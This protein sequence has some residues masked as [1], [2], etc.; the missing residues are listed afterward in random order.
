MPTP[1]SDT[2]RT[3][4]VPDRFQ[5]HADHAAPRSEL[6]R[7]RDEVVEELGEAGAISVDHRSLLDLCVQTDSL[8]RRGGASRFDGLFDEPPEI[9][10]GEREL[11]PAGVDLGDEEEVADETQKALAVP[12]D[13]RK[14]L[15]LL[16][17]KIL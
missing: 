15:T 9:R 8:F 13:D 1:V 7:V 17:P 12:V 11:E 2:S 5:V 3:A 6:E 4:F 16:R 14:E 10:F